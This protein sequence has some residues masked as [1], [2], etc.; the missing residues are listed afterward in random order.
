MTPKVA[1]FIDRGWPVRGVIHI[2]ASDGEEV[3]GYKELGITNILC[4]EPLQSA[5]DAF[6]V[7]NPDVV[8]LPFGLGNKTGVRTLNISAGNGK[9]TSALKVIKD[10]PEVV[11]KWNHGQADVVGKQKARFTRFDDWYDKTTIPLHLF[12]CVVIDAQ[13]MSYEVLEGFGEYLDFIDYLIV[14]LSETPVYQKEQPADVVV[15][16]LAKKGFEQLTPIHP[17]D[18][19]LFRR[20][21]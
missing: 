20:A 17:H 9:G 7:K 1:Y 2:G 12:D 14:E 13:G 16:F 15:S 19:V 11:E 18:D 6:K 3:Q 4:F 10:H 5:I 21:E 8:C